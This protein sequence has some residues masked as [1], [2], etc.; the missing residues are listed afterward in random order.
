MI[1]ALLAAQATTPSLELTQRAANAAFAACQ[2]TPIAVAIIDSDAQPRL[3]LLGD[4]TRSMFGNFAIRK[5]TTALRFGKPSAEVRDAAKSDPALAERLKSDATLI[6]FGGGL[7]YAGGAVAVAG[8]PS[9]DLDQTCAAAAL[10]V[11]TKG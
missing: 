1:L 2:G 6:G 3:L 4:G 9:Q 10:A 8:A 11:L 7:P 5:A